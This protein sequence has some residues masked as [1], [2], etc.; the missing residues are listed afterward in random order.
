MNNLDNIR[1]ILFDLDG[2][3]FVGD[4]AIAGAADV[5][6]HVQRKQ[7]P[8]RY[9]TNTT[10]QSRDT[11]ANKLQ[12]MGLSIQNHEIIS[13]PYAAVLYLRQQ[14]F[15]SCHLLVADEVKSE[16]AEYRD[17]TD[18]PDAIIIGDIGD[19]WHYDLLN[20]VFR[21]VMQGSQLIALHKGKFWETAEGLRMDIGAFVA[22]LEYVTGKQAVIIGKPSEAF[23]SLAL[24]Q[25]NLPKQQVLMVGDDIDSDVGGAQRSGLRSAL[26]KTGKYRAG[27]AASSRIKPDVLLDSVA[28]LPRFL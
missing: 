6:A 19:A 23:F 13:T 17:D 14:G 22:G 15:K 24:Q 25:L 21:L 12:A 18:Q 9:V 8:F 7:M 1:G 2:V 10:T 4:Q 3:F 20:R 28:D 16:F 11:M 5:I 26:V 27:Y